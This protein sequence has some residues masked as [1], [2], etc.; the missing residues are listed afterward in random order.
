AYPTSPTYGPGKTAP[1]GYRYCFQHSPVGALFAA[2][3]ALAQGS[4]TG[5]NAAWS[6][7]VL[8]AGPHRAELLAQG[9]TSSG[10]SGSRTTIQG[11]RLLSYDG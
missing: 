5:N 4:A 2:A 3:N 1:E 6:Q 10:T 7:Y 9:T 11:F 8:A